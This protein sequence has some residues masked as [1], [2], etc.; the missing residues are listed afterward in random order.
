MGFVGLIL[1][2]LILNYHGDIPLE[3]LKERYT[4][5]ESKF[6]AIGELQV[7][8]RDEGAGAGYPLV[9][10]HGTSSSLHTWDGW[11]A[12]LKDQLRVIRMDI[13]GF[14]LTGPNATNDY[15]MVAYCDFLKEFLDALKIDTCYLA[16]NSLGGEI[17]W[18]FAERYPAMVEKAILIDAGGYKHDAPFVIK[19]AISPLGPLF[20]NITPRYIV[21]RSVYEVYGDDTKVK[22]SLI[23]LY[24]DLALR[25]GNRDA[26]IA[27]A[28]VRRA[29]NIDK[30]STINVPTLIMW[31]KE[32]IWID[33]S[34]AYLFHRDLANSE[35]I[36]YPGVGHI[37]MEEIP[38][39][40]AKDARRFLLK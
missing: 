37:P 26:F 14:G 24:Y 39:L 13:P 31:G 17:V 3:V 5:S 15:S 1:L 12:A 30:L 36:L 8:Y 6:I 4:N 21:A 18:N 22:D 16:G 34:F 20:K 10:I 28:K 35:L 2:V 11:T 9:L 25:E 19:L 33:T 27:R 29:T 7:H 23:D 32:D 38:L 40:T